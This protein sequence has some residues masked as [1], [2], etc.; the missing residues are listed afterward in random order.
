MAELW[1][2][3]KKSFAGLELKEQGEITCL[4]L[5]C[6]EMFVLT[7]DVVTILKNM[8]ELFTMQ[9]LSHILSKNSVVTTKC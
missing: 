3:V 6:T 9:G 2:Q 7:M 8:F 4:Y 1:E 5:I